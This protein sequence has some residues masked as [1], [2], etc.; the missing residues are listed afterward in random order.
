MTDDLSPAP[1]ASHMDTSTSSVSPLK[2]ARGPATSLMTAEW[3]VDVPIDL[4]QQWLVAAR[5]AGRRCLVTTSGGSTRAHSRHGKPRTFPSAL[6]NGSRATRSGLCACELD[7]IFCEEDQ[8]Y[9]ILDVLRWKDQAMIDCPSD[10]RL[11]WLASKLTEGNA[12]V[13]TSTNPCRFVPLAYA[14][15]TPEALRQAYSGPFQF[16]CAQ[17][18]LLLL[19]REALYEPG[20]SPLLLSWSDASSSARFYDY[21]SEQFTAA[22]T[23]DP[24]KG[25]RWRAGQVETACGFADLLRISETEPSAGPMEGMQLELT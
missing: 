19:H 12:S 20:P 1:S 25:E 6:P 5:P 10:F 7:C 11:W 22:V 17:D 13:Q 21:G 16:A 24:A 8:T 9:Y 4:A 15:C 18:G 14:P 2:S 3:M 23:A